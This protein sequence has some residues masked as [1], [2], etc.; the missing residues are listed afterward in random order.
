MKTHWI[1]LPD[2]TSFK[3]HRAFFYKRGAPNPGPQ[4]RVPETRAPAKFYVTLWLH[5]FCFCFFCH[6]C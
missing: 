2:C 4:D 5:H 6:F 3:K 1:V